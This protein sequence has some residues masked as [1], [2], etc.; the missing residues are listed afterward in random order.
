MMSYT[1]Y[2]MSHITARPGDM[3]EDA[4]VM[5]HTTCTMLHIT[6]GACR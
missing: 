6:A 1:P 2:T 3:A 4:A 5:Y